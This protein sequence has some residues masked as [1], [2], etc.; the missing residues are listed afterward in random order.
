MNS[1]E[2]PKL[3]YVNEETFISCQGFE[4]VQHRS[5]TEGSGRTR[6][7][8]VGFSGMF[9]AC[10]GTCSVSS[11]LCCHMHFMFRHF[12]IY[13][14]SPAFANECHPATEHGDRDRVNAR[15]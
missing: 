9:G 7:R 14:C 10:P 15:A 8:R 3:I 6:A 1:A 13:K 11:P 4:S 12:L 5:Q 2:W